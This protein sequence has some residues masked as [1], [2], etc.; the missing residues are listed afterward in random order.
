[1]TRRR[2]PTGK[3]SYH[4]HSEAKRAI[5]MI[6]QSSP[7]EDHQIPI[8]AYQCPHCWRWHLTHLPDGIFAQP[9]RPMRRSN[10]TRRATLRSR[11]PLRT[12]KPLEAMS[13]R[14]RGESS[15]YTAAKTTVWLRDL[16]RCQAEGLDGVPHG[17]PKDPHHV[18]PLGQGGPRCDPANMIIV[19]RAAH[20]W[21]HTH[22][23]QA[24]LHGLLAVDAESLGN[25]VR[26][27]N[28]E[29]ADR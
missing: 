18:W 12:R 27:R 15:A 2:C 11:T 28:G 10:L 7:P 24:E 23:Q 6:R 17:G 3:R 22:R 9:D 14:R 16:G 4:D 20:E 5:T 26:L 29:G 21:I 25:I 13:K 8:R 19:C 1:M